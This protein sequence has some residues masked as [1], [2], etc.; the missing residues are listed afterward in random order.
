MASLQG[1]PVQIQDASGNVVGSGV[2]DASGAASVNMPGA[3]SDVVYKAVFPGQPGYFAPSASDFQ[4]E[5]I[6]DQ[7][8]QTTTVASGSPN[9]QSPSLPWTISVQVTPAS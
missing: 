1:I 3:S 4:R 8:K 7:T 5:S 9:P 2:L 6:V